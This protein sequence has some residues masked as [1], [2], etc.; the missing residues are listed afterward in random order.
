MSEALLFDINAQLRLLARAEVRCAND[1]R[2]LGGVIDARLEAMRL[3]LLDI[4]EQAQGGLPLSPEEEAHVRVA[5]ATCR[6]NNLLIR[7]LR[8][9]LERES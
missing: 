6:D 3:R 2:R 8:R 7:Q 4:L 5:Q 9:Q 1:G